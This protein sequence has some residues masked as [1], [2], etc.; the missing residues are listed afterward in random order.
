MQDQTPYE[1]AKGRETVVLREYQK[2]DRAALE[3]VIRE[4][5]HYDRFCSP[6]T[7]KKLARVYLAGCLAN[8]TFTQVA[9][10][11]G[12]PVGV[13]MGKNCR[14]HTCPPRFRLG[15]IRSVCSLL[16][17][18]EG[19]TVSKMFSCVEEIDRDLLRSSPIGYQ[20]EVAFFAVSS[21]YRGKGLGKKLFQA[22]RDY[23]KSE[24][25]R[26]FFLFTDTSCNY[27]FYERQ[28]ME[29]RGERRHTFQAK[30][31]SGT[32]TLFLYDHQGS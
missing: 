19:R 7:A 18:R 31:Q 11:D 10:V 30:G 17:S 9:E 2:A 28:G 12:V 23:L 6:S 32:L 4:T 15:L 14:K 8:Q 22:L 24:D 3:E 29:R 21:Q 27:A 13:I 16:L 20:G 26:S 1:T 25:I 5:W